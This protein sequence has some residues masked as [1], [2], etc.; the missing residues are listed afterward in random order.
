VECR[1]EGRKVGM[2]N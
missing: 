2:N 1:C